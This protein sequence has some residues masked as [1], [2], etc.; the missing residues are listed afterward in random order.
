M[1]GLW[2]WLMGRDAKMAPAACAQNAPV[3]ITTSSKNC[4]HR[5][6]ATVEAV[7]HRRIRLR[8]KCAFGFRPGRQLNVEL[9]AANGLPADI[10]VACIVGVTPYSGG[11]WMLDCTF[12][13]DL[14]DQ[15]LERVGIKR[16]QGHTRSFP[17]HNV[18][19]PPHNVGHFSSD[20]KAAYQHLEESQTFSTKVVD[21][22]LG[23]ID[24]LVPQFEEAGT[25]LSLEL[26]S[27]S[28]SPR[29][30]MLA[31]V[32]RTTMQGPRQF[33]L[34]CTFLRELAEEEFR[35]LAGDHR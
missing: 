27:A 7:S 22:S 8:V 24:L 31:C 4:R 33:V 35:A 29:C 13:R 23:G 9:P 14:R 17:P 12:S 32:V 18:K 15:D 25:V 30:T 21:M 1:L 6:L 10:A 16:H 11:E 26:A 5:F 2:R 19:H 3:T 28:G 20:L 34:G